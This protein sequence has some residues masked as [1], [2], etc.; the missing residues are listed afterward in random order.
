[1]ISARGGPAA[2]PAAARWLERAVAP[3][4]RLFDRIYGSRWNPLHQSGNLAVLCLLVSIAT[5]LYLFLFYRI[6]EPYESVLRIEREVFLGAWVRSLHRLSADL[7]IVAAAV[8]LVRKL[9][10]GH[11][12]GPRVLAWVSGVVLLG[13]LLAC[14]WTGLVMVWDTQGLEI[15][16]RGARLIDLLPVMSQP[17]ARAFDG[18]Q[19]VPSSFFF[20]NLF[21][22]VAIPLG[23]AAL[24]W[25]H[26]SRVARPVWLPPPSVRRW[27]LA[28]LA[29]AAILV[30][31][32]IGPTAD[33]LALPGEVP[34]D[35]LYAF[36]LPLAR[37]VEPAAQAL[38]WLALFGG[39]TALAW[40]WRPRAPIRFSSVDQDRCTGCESCARD[41][42][43]EAITMVPRTAGLV[44][45]A[46]V[47]WVD[48]ARCVGCGICAAACA[49]MG[50]GPTDWTGREQ[51]AA[52][53]ARLAGAAL[54]GREIL[55]LGCRNGVVRERAAFERPGVLVETV[56]CA[57]SLHTAG[58]EL[59]L[60]QGLGGVLLL[61]CPP[62]D[63]RFREGPKWLAARL[64]D[65]REA[66]LPERVDRRRIAFA[67]FSASES[68]AAAR[69][70]AELTARVAALAPPP[71]DAAEP[72]IEC[73]TTTAATP[74]AVGAGRG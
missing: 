19:P 68:S 23:L 69:A 6:A 2:P 48:P 53:R 65:G 16:A 35:L 46:T 45:S 29:L 72:E 71:V 61:A 63:C 27:A 41:C 31:A 18:A 49:P 60:R 42:P 74:V 30:P 14:G 54:T 5:G 40:T 67:S 55:V 34:T 59:A 36:W 25:L 33:L 9:L 58:V 10:A 7:A 4:E 13:T 50:V 70:I 1:M 11:T 17:L 12:W 26:V 37:R 28:A 64:F 24:L 39:L 73:A 66:E 8:H 38:F 44:R 51:L 57:G 21:L 43:Y 56:P 15:A 47:A 62:R 32:G 22:H 3:L 20:M 52:L